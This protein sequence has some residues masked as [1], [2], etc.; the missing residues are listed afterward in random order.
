M[1][2]LPFFKSKPDKAPPPNPVPPVVLLVLDGWGLA[3]PSR[4]NAITIANT[5]NMDTLM[6]RFPHGALIASGEAVGL[7]ANEVGNTEVGHLNMGA[8]RVIYQSFKRI[9][10]SIKS[11]EFYENPALLSAIDEARKNRSR[12]NVVG[13][14][15]KGNVHASLEHLYGLIDLLVKKKVRGAAFHLFT[16]GRDSPPQSGIEVLPAV[17]KKLA[18]KQVGTVASISGRYFAMDRDSRWDRTQKVYDAMSMG[19]GLR[20]PSALEA[21]KASYA[22]GKTDEFVEPVLVGESPLTVR[23][24]DSVIFFNFRVDRIR[25]ITRAFVNSKD[26]PV[27]FKKA[28]QPQNLFI[29][30]MAEYEE[31][32]PVGAIAYPPPTIDMS[33]PEVIAKAGFPQ[34]HLSES[35][36]DRFV[37][38]YFRGMKEEKNPLEEVRIVPSPRV[39]SYDKKPEMSVYEL[40]REFEKALWE[41]RYRFFVINFANPDMVAHSGNIEATIKALEHTDVAVGKVAEAV[42][43]FNGTLI[44]TGD[45]GN[46]EELLTFP[47]RS[48]YYT[49]TGGVLNTDHSNNPVP[50]VFV[51][52]GLA[53]RAVELPQG[54]LTDIATTV[55]Y[56]LGIE[57]PPQMTGRNLLGNM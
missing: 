46:A 23:D 15:G 13:L 9:S 3:P 1:F 37:T 22:A 47:T 30:T 21:L 10:N 54:A 50:V 7:P 16:D 20:A 44:V 38:Y 6:A 53:G 39:G 26:F 34:M 43:K 56:L 18:E 2:E 33:L 57:P 8:G 5:P 27:H 17:E 35:E 41:N 32:L 51:N 49:T 52:N 29:T 25:Q 24:Y 55:C 14:A 4:G 12:V 19:A 36:K 31:G 42:L 48:F 45:H 28:V 40:A 11:G